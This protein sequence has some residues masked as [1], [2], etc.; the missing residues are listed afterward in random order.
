MSFIGNIKGLGFEPGW[1]LVHDEKCTRET[2]QIAQS[3]ASSLDD[4][5]K[6]VKMGT[7]YPA[8]NSTAIGIVYEDVE[9]TLGDA[10]GSVVTSG[11][12]YEDRLPEALDSDA[13]SALA[14]LGFKFVQSVPAVTRP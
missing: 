12:V 1:F 10:P 6:Y 7:V 3:G 4:G 5:T 2:R 13:K 11:T 8:N 9:V 14:A